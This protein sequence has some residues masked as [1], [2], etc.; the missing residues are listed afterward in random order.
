[1]LLCS[2][3]LSSITVF[4]PFFLPGCS[5]LSAVKDFDRKGNP[6]LGKGQRW[7]REQELS[8]ACV[9]AALQSER[10]LTGCAIRSLSDTLA[11]CSASVTDGNISNIASAGKENMSTLTRRR[12][13]KSDTL[14]TLANNHG[15]GQL[16]TSQQHVGCLYKYSGRKQG[17][18]RRRRRCKGREPRPQLMGE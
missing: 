7:R 5:Y 2:L 16:I 17:R 12:D 11:G 9:H 10:P 3:F 18:R 13:I 1:M 6:T 4:P 14:S 8:G 15:Y